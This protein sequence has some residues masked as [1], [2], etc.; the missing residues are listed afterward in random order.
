MVATARLEYG[1]PFNRI[2]QVLPVCISK[3]FLGPTRVSPPSA[4]RSVRPFLQSSRSSSSSP[5]LCCACMRCALVI[6]VEVHTVGDCIYWRYKLASMHLSTIRNNRYR[7]R[8][9]YLVRIVNAG[10]GRVYTFPVIVRHQS[11]RR[12]NAMTLSCINE[13]VPL[14]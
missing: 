8:P 5:H 4:S 2:R 7:G 12:C 14:T 9:V 11:P 6:T 3:W 1:R 10:T 13:T